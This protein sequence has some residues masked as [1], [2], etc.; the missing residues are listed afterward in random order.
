MTD[1]TSTATATPTAPD[2][3]PNTRLIDAELD[4]YTAAAPIG[5]PTKLAPIQL[6]RKDPSFSTEWMHLTDVIPGTGEPDL[7]RLRPRVVLAIRSQ[8]DGEVRVFALHPE[9]ALAL[10]DGLKFSMAAS[11]EPPSF[12]PAPAP[13]PTP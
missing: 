9:L 11:L 2:A 10:I 5:R 13:T 1:V 4:P 3:A 12:K 6:W 7:T 8:E